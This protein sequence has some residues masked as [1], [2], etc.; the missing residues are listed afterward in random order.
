MPSEPTSQPPDAKEIRITLR[1]PADLHAALQQM[2]KAD[3]RSLNR[4][5]VALLRTAAEPIV[6]ADAYRESR[7][8]LLSSMPR[9]TF[10]RPTNRKPRGGG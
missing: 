7:R 10:P 2:A 9:Y 3:D 1:L 4:E 6:D 5:I 8:K